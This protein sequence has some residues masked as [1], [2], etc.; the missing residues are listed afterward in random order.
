[1]TVPVRLRVMMG[2]R[3]WVCSVC[4]R[5]VDGR[6]LSWLRLRRIWPLGVR[7]TYER[8]ALAR[9]TVVPVVGFPLVVTYTSVSIRYCWQVSDAMTAVEV[10][11]LSLLESV[12]VLL[13]F[14]QVR[15]FGH[16]AL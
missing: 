7:I 6:V 11:L 15:P 9:A 1:M 3:S 5:V 13:E 10:G 2:L 16:Q 4:G 14:L 8:G 12:V